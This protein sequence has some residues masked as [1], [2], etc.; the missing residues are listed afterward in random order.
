MF[1]RALHRRPIRTLAP[2]ALAAA[3][4]VVAAVGLSGCVSGSALYTGPASTTSAA[5]APTVTTGAT[6]TSLPP[7]SRSKPA[8]VVAGK[9]I[10]GADYADAANEV[11][12]SA[13]QQAQQ[14]PGSPLPTEAQI[15]TVALNGLIDRAVVNH[16]AGQHGISVTS[17]EVQRTYDSYQVRYGT[18]V[19]FTQVLATFG[20]T[21][22]SF[23]AVVHDQVLRTKVQS[24]VAPIPT[25]VMEVRVRHILVRTK[26]L[27]DSIATQLQQNPS[28]FASLA[29]KY[30][31]DTGSAANG[32]ELGYL[33]HGVTVAPFDKAIFSLKQGRIS[34]PVQSQYGYHIIEVEGSKTVAYK[35]LDAQTQQAVTTYAFRKW[36]SGQRAQDNVRILVPGVTL[37]VPH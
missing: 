37:V 35:S 27:A 30:S 22:A 19:S 3:A 34:T 28:L 9:T 24:K 36:L 10:A 17:A 18:P 15:R 11:R 14:Q 12:L 29:K 20:Y 2:R 1:Y 5:S 16:Y 25:T 7:I 6:S 13:M 8:A 26:A 4:L 31:V 23:K 21:P 33:A 32:G